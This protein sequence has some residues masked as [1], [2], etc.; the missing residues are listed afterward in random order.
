MI[1]TVSGV[2]IGGGGLTFQHKFADVVGVLVR[3]RERVKL[4]VTSF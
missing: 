1:Q 4:L 3:S 2:E